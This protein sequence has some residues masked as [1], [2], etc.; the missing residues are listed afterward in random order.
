MVSEPHYSGLFSS[1]LGQEMQKSKAWSFYPGA[2]RL[3]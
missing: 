2:D 3:I 1:L